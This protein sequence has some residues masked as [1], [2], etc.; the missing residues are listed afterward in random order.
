M[1]VESIARLVFD[2]RELVREYPPLFHHDHKRMLFERITVPI[3]GTLEVSRWMGQLPPAADLVL[4]PQ[5]EMREDV[6]SYPAEESGTR[7][8]HLNFADAELFGFYAGPLL[9]Q[10]EHQVLEHPVLGS[11]REML[12]HLHVTRP[13]FAP[14]TRDM[15]PTPY[16]VKGAQRSLA[17]DTVNGPYGNAFSRESPERILRATTFLDPPTFSNILAMEAPKP[18]FGI[19]TR[20]EIQDVLETA[21]IGFSASKAESGSSQTLVHTGNWGCGAYGGNHVLMALLQHTA[22]QLAG[23][24]RLV[25]HTASAQ[26]SEACREAL[27]HLE[28]LVPETRVDIRDLIDAIYAKGFK[29]GQPDGN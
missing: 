2:A 4:R 12:R 20:D 29:W 25:Y 14:R 27:A 11:L 10:D 16:L 24:D 18:G 5:F 3:T 8:W 9:A 7:A 28:E 6:F 1:P 23:V 13:E 19:Y 17:F 15:G 22:A 26:G 21:F